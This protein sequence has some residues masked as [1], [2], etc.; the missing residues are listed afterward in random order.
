MKKFS[1]RLLTLCLSS[2]LLLLCSFS[3]YPPGPAEAKAT[4]KSTWFW[5]TPLIENA[6]PEILDFASDQGVNVLYLQMN[7]DVRPEHY[8][9]FIR[10]AGRQ[11]IEVHV[12]GGAPNW[13]LESERH[14]LE[15]F[16]QWTAE[17]QASA[18]PDERFAG[19]HVDIEP[20][21]LGEWKTNYDAVV[22]QWQNNVRY[23]VKEAHSLNLPIAADMT[24]WLHTYK[25]PDQS[26]TLS[27]WMIQQFDQIV[28]MAYRDSAQN[29]YNLA[30]AELAEADKYGKEALVAVE[31]KSSNEGNYVTFFEEGTAF[32]EKELSKVT[33][34]AG[35]HASFSGTAVHEY[36]SW[37]ELYGLNR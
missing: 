37:K 12:L 4:Q 11:G 24:F 25:L 5:E 23:L 7:R 16:I 26:M 19:I 18:A 22:K 6:T 3:M 36:R 28:I 33:A 9:K 15:T 1:I 13:A 30:A 31:T 2:S 21:V 34:L 20:H 10:L 14:R 29:I 17:Y 27:S 35:G 8:R 32:M